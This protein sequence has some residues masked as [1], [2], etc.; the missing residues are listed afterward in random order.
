MAK[1]PPNSRTFNALF[2]RRGQ[3]D[4]IDVDFGSRTTSARFRGSG[5]KGVVQWNPGPEILA[6]AVE[7]CGTRLLN[8]ISMTARSTAAEMRADARILAESKYENPSSPD[9]ASAG[10]STAVDGS[11]SNWNIYLFHGPRTINRGHYYG[12]NLER[13]ANQYG[14][15]D[16][17]TEVIMPSINK[18]GREFM[19]KLDG[20]LVRGSAGNASLVRR[21]ERVG[22]TG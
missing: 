11:G 2:G 14:K 17:P 21:L 5:L 22:I 7:E 10:L 20:A 12:R 8:N 3:F 9:R 13:E 19:R 4:A 15:Y 6:K 16:H 1:A 18:W